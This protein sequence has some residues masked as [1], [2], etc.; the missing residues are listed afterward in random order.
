[1]YESPLIKMHQ[2]IKKRG[3]VMSEHAHKMHQHQEKKEGKLCLSML[4]KGTSS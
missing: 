1:M 3:N 4:I 2:Q